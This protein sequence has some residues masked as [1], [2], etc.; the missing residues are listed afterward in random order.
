MTLKPLNDGALL[1]V[2][3]KFSILAVQSPHPEKT[4]EE[5]SRKPVVLFHFL[6]PRPPAR[7]CS[8]KQ[9]QPQPRQLLALLVLSNLS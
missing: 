3:S 9:F 5:G 6:F 7:V 1:S 4:E 2:V 8:M